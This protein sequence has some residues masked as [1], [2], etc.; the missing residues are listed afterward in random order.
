MGVGRSI[1]GR[2]AG[3]PDRVR[4]AQRVSDRYSRLART[5]TAPETALRKELH[6]RGRRFRVHARIEGLPR[7]RADI[8]FTRWRVAVFVDGCFWHSCPVHGSVPLTN[9]EWWEWKLARTQARDKDTDDQLS[10]LGWRAVHVWEH[11]SAEVAAST[12]EKALEAAGAPPS[13]QA[14]PSSPH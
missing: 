12:V 3:E 10:A 11:L 9:R 8:V 6:R 4:P 1:A 7:R 14:H 2:D 5:G 13:S